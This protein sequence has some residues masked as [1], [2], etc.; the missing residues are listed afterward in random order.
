MYQHFVCMH[1]YAPCAHLMSE[2]IKREHQSWGYEWL[3]IMWSLRTQLN[4]CKKTKPSFHPTLSLQ[5]T[6]L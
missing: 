3:T 4:L 2:E 6:V 1:I 5:D